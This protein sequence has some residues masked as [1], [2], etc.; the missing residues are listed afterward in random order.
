MTDVVIP[1]PV[2]L[3]GR[4]RAVRPVLEPGFTFDP[5]RYTPLVAPHGLLVDPLAQVEVDRSVALFLDGVI[6]R[7]LHRLPRRAPR[8]AIPSG[9]TVAEAGWGGSS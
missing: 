1:V 5:G 3:A 7:V 4:R 2:E 9:M 8:P 6:S